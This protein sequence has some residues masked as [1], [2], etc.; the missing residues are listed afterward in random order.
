MYRYDLRQYIRQNVRI[1]KHLDASRI[2]KGTNNGTASVSEW[3]PQLCEDMDKII[4]NAC[5]LDF[6]HDHTGAEPLDWI[7]FFLQPKKKAVFSLCVYFDMKTGKFTGL[8][9]IW[10]TEEEF[11][12]RGYGHSYIRKTATKDEIELAEKEVRSVLTSFVR[13]ASKLGYLQ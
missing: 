13:K 2:L 8:E 1:N 10:F 5:Y 9:R 7:Y 3:D 11:S 4:G 6:D 12:H